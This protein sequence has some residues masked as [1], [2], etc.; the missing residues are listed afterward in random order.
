MTRGVMSVWAA[1]AVVGLVAGPAVAQTTGGALAVGRAVSGTFADGAEPVLYT[2]EA[3]EDTFLFGEVQQ[4]SVDVVIRILDAKGEAIGRFDG[5]DRGPERFSRRL[6]QAGA[7]QIEVAPFE[8]ATGDYAITILRLE[9]VE[10]DP[11]RLTDQLL[12]PYAGNDRPGAAVQVWRDGQTVYAAAYGMANLAYGV[13]F[14]TNTR[15]NIGS[16]SKQFTAFAIMLQAQR[17]ALSLDDDIRKHIP[18]LPE[19]DETITVRHLITHTSGLREFLNL[20]RMTGRR[21]DHGDWIDRAELI[22]IVRR[23]PALQNAPG[24]EFNYN[25][26]AFGLAAVIVER[27]SGQPFHEFLRKNVFEPLDMTRSMVR[28]DPEQIVPESSEGYTPGAGGYRQIGD[29][30]GAVGAGGIYTTVEDL[31]RWVQNYANPHVG[32]AEIVKEMMTPFVMTNGKETGYGYGLFVDEQRGLKRV[33][34]GGADVAHRSM[35]VYYPEINAGLTVQSND[36]TFSSNVAFELAEAFFGDAMEP[37]PDP[38]AEAASGEAFDPAS[39]DAEDF[40]AFVGRYSLDEAPA[41]ILTFT[42][43]GET[44]YTQA[45]GQPRIEVVP[46]SPTSFRLLGVEASVTF[47]QNDDDEVT[48]LTLFQNGER[49]ATRL[50]GEA[51][52]RWEPTADDLEAFAGRYFS[53]ELETYYT[54]A[55]EEGALVVQHRRLDEFRLRPGEP[56]RFAGGGFTFAFERDRNRQVIG[57]YLANGRTRDVRFERVR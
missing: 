6:R 57:F 51:E 36:A 22:D 26:T 7:Y 55:V 14:T 35:L 31:Q 39:F 45:T 29:L 21:L 37:V 33:H 10:K 40:D 44:F 3:G 4:I 27:T 48:G 23:Q 9:P 13:P 49:H 15:T 17:G 1:V 56:D 19:F 25:N 16:T 54:I 8:G 2:F 28:P 12:S 46:T 50:A 5:P 53:E 34:H 47:L 11:R 18:E 32:S 30:G 41:F 52:A 38:D 43:E 24:A 20:L 42:R